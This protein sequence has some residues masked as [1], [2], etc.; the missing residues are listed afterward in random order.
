MTAR[1]ESGRDSHGSRRSARVTG[2][3][4]TGE[5]FQ[6]DG[7]RGAREGRRAGIRPRR[8]RPSSE[9]SGQRHRTSTRTASTPDSDPAVVATALFGALK[10]PAP[11]RLRAGW[12]RA[13][14]LGATLG[15]DRDCRD[16]DSEPKR[17]SLVRGAARRRRTWARRIQRRRL[18]QAA[19]DSRITRMSEAGRVCNEYG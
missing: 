9:R 19:G 5:G 1:L 3:V 18:P 2:R 6:V 12:R 15:A 7:E 4:V 14:L 13:A 11:S 10:L 17:A 16:T 8:P